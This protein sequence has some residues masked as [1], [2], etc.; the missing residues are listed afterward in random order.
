MGQD[1][2]ASVHV[3]CTLCTQVNSIVYTFGNITC[4][5]F[6]WQFTSSLLIY[7][8]IIITD[9]HRHGPHDGPP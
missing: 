6:Y 2:T 1:L 9:Y 5:A 7:H 8:L 3:H 4:M